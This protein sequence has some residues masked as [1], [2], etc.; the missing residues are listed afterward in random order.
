M[1]IFRKKLYFTA[2][3]ITFLSSTVF[4]MQRHAS[5]AVEEE[6]LTEVV[7]VPSEAITQNNV[8]KAIAQENIK[9][10]NSDGAA[11]GLCAVQA[12]LE[13]NG[14][15]AFITACADHQIN[16]NKES[17]QRLVLELLSEF[18]DKYPSQ[19][20]NSNIMDEVTWQDLNLLCGPKSNP[21]MYLAEKITEG[22]AVSAIGIATIFRM[23]VQPTADIRKLR[24]QQEITKELV[25][26]EQLFN[27]LN[28]RLNELVIPENILLSFWDPEDV[29]SLIS[30]QNKTK[31][32]FDDKFDS[33]K[34]ISD[35][36]NKS[37][38]TLES[39]SRAEELL[40]YVG[41]FLMAYGAVALPVY[42][43]SGQSIIPGLPAEQFNYLAPCTMLWVMGWVASR[44]NQSVHNKLYTSQIANGT[45]GIASTYAYAKAA[46]DAVRNMDEGRV[47]FKYFHQKIYY[48][49][50]YLNN[51]K[52]MENFI[53]CHPVLASRMPA[54]QNFSQLLKK[55]RESTSDFGYLI[56]ILETGTFKGEYAWWEYFSRVMVAYKLM[57]EQKEQFV[58]LMLAVGELDA[59]LTIAKLYKEFQGKRVTFCFPE[60]IESSK[61]PIVCV[62]DSWNPFLDPEKA[63]SN[64][65]EIG[66]SGVPQNVI[67]TGPNAGGKSTV[68]KA[69]IFSFVLGQTLGIA[70]AKALSFTPASILMTYLNVIDDFAA[71]VSH[72]KACVINA[73]SI[74]QK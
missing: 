25:K 10:L 40:G 42:A 51:L 9:S 29:F 41:K 70:P 45:K 59:Q 24:A 71:G 56:K 65:I 66:C 5:H 16:P 44:V 69:L 2:F 38:V 52:E 55:L 15:K 22:R 72:Y 14:F 20:T 32:P 46:Y 36:I 8:Y 63:V 39:Y 73:N 4:G 11:A 33:L 6:G 35:W 67:I 26:D 3:I 64:S 28:A 19:K 57:R 50:K 61:N 68:T 60:F 27:D 49:A 12:E 37:P 13:K 18:Y 31:I 53:A 54:V 74:T 43:V 21:R 23:L 17:R 34:K 30:E 58:P 1:F 62:Q 7:V 47:F 48:V